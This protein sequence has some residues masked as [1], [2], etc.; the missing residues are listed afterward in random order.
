MLGIWKDGAGLVGLIA[1]SNYIIN[2]IVYKSVQTL[3]ELLVDVNPD[4][5]HYGNCF[6]ANL[7][8]HRPCGLH[9]NAI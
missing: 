4:L 3:R 6:R 1:N 8:R 7:T 2:A 9:I 5:I